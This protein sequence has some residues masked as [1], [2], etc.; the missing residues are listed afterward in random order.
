MFLCD[1]LSQEKDGGKRPTA[2]ELIRGLE[3]NVRKVLEQKRHDYDQLKYQLK[4]QKT[5]LAQLETELEDLRKDGKALGL[6]EYPD[7]KE[8]LKPVKEISTRPVFTKHTVWKFAE[9]QIARPIFTRPCR[10]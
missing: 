3:D 6:D 10:P 8:R 5:L 7:E 4:K 2:K 9:F 1:V